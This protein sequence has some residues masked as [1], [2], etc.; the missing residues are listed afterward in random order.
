MPLQ[1]SRVV[2]VVV[3]EL[4]VD[5]VDVVDVVGQAR[6]QLPLAA[7]PPATS[8]RADEG[9][10]RQRSPPPANVRRHAAAPGLPHVERDA[11]LTTAPLHSPGSA[12]PRTR[13][14]AARETHWT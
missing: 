4:L 2:V 12:L 14:L 7:V 13:S 10:M 8:H 5:D 1:G 3:V 9:L 11:Q 6:Q